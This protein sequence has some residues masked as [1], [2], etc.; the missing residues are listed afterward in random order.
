[1]LGLARDDN[2]EMTEYVVT[3]IL[4][5]KKGWYRGPGKFL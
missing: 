4:N 1:M 2:K 5:L 3:S